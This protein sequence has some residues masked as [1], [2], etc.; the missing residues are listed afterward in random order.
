MSAKLIFLG[1]AS[2]VSYPGHENAFM[3]IKGEARS[4]L[5]DCSAIP[6]RRLGDAGVDF[7]HLSD[8]II[9]HFH[10]DHVS[11]LATL[12]ME[13]WIKGRTKEFHIHGCEHAISRAMQLLEL[14]G[15]KDWGGMYPVY[16]HT[17]PLEELTLVLDGDDFKVWSSPGEHL[18]PSIGIRVEDQESEFTLAYTS[19]TEPIP[20]MERLAKGVDVLIHEAAGNAPFHSSPSQAGEVAANADA[21]A[22]YLIH[23]PE[24]FAN[25]PETALEDAKKTFTG[26]VYLAED[27]MEIDFIRG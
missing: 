7:N 26:K 2:A 14:F 15:W 3:V 20:E 19:D 6:L 21:K 25:N 13:M 1:T 16:F 9:T 5:I 12:I 4:V 23:Y 27:L 8:L 10:P 17:L 11:G 18:I 24:T 22:L